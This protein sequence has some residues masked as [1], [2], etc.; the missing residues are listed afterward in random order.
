MILQAVCV[1]YSFLVILFSKRLSCQ[2]KK[3]TMN[4]LRTNTNHIRHAIFLS[5]TNSIAANVLINN[6]MSIRQ[7][8]AQCHPQ[9]EL[10]DH[11][12]KLYLLKSFLEAMLHIHNNFSQSC[13]KYMRS[14][15]SSFRSRNHSSTSTSHTLASS[16]TPPLLREV[17]KMKGNKEY[18][19]YGEYLMV[20]NRVRRP[21]K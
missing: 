15:L 6:S 8:L 9:S 21:T 3:K 19:G 1:N 7:S 13:F 11:S 2:K 14:T 10:V 4:V 17:S 12:T 16:T 5:I 20:K 18:I